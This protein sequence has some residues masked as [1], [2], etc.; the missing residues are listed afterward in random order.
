MM[1]CTRAAGA[2]R[3]LAPNIKSLT[4]V[5]N[6]NWLD[7]PVMT[8]GS[9]DVLEVGF[10]E[11]SHDYHRLVYRIEHCEADWTVSDEL[12]ESEWLAGFNGNPIEDYQNS[13]NTTVMY[14]HYRLTIPNDKCRLRMSGNYRLTVTDEDDDGR[15]LLE[16]EFY[17]VEPL[18]DIGLAAT[19]NTDI[20]HNGSHQ[21]LSMTLV[22]NGMRI[23]DPAEE[24]YT[25]VMQNWREDKARRNIRPNS[26]TPRQMVWEHNR[27]LIF[28]GGNEY[29]KFEV[30]DVSHPT[31]GIDR[32]EWDGS[33][34]QAYPFAA[35]VSQNYLTDVDADGAFQIRNSERSEID[36]TCEYVW[37]NYELQ[38]PYEGE[39]YIRGLWTV[40][41]DRATYR[42]TY[43]EEAH[44][45][46]ASVMQKEG[47][48]SYQ[49]VRAD[50]EP[51]HAEG[52]YFQTENRYQAMVYYKGSGGRTWRLVGY[53]GILMKN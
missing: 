8:L 25:V 38:A 14:T 34:Y 10:D 28:D 24:L 52:S 27:E 11:L 3:V 31:M 45:Y 12:F 44:V 41:A 23:T 21:Q 18:M 16:V 2:N 50:G 4:S 32:I 1:V 42:M 39:L 9:S 46:R 51:A 15:R 7:R 19:T 6:G 29:H 13:I 40:D 49:I 22:Y 33:S 47:Y 30:L 53:R 37:V 5:V 48:Y 26:V 43:D 17:V 36:Y 20:D 35:T